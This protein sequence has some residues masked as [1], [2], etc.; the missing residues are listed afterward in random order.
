MHTSESAHLTWTC[1]LGEDCDGEHHVWRVLHEA[2][3][4]A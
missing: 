1:V 3:D 2:T 4:A